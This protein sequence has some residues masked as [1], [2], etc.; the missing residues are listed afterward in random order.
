MLANEH[1]H[2]T[3]HTS[4]S[5]H[6]FLS[7]LHALGHS[8]SA[9]RFTT[10]SHTAAAAADPRSR[11]KRTIPPTL[12]ASLTQNVGLAHAERRDGRLS[13]D[14]VDL[15]EGNASTIIRTRHHESFV[16]TGVRRLR[17]ASGSRWIL[18]LQL[19]SLSAHHSTSPE[20]RVPRQRLRCLEKSTW[21]P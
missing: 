1:I 6:M 4:L 12:S 15:E 9:L 8:P 17:T 10:A 13:D 14:R 11:Q 5:Q 20:A 21:N 19:L 2:V 3:K 16:D 18:L 7:R